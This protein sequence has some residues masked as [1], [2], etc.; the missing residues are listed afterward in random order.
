VPVQLKTP[1]EVSN[2]KQIEYGIR[3]LVNYDEILV[4]W[5]KTQ[6][7]R[8]RRFAEAPKEL[9]DLADR[10]EL[11]VDRFRKCSTGKFFCGTV[12]VTRTITRMGHYLRRR[13]TD[14]SEKSS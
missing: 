1:D 4:I 13:K 11:T 12:T 2:T 10:G 7:A 14:T 9:R 5:W 8:W 6:G 3:M